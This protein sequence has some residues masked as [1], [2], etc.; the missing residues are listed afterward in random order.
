MPKQ[1]LKQI[2]AAR[3]EFDTAASLCE[4]REFP[5]SIDAANQVFGILEIQNS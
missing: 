2:A 1:L 5:D 3:V 4:S